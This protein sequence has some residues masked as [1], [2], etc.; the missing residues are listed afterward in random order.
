MMNDPQT[1]D[2]TG[3][4]KGSNTPW[5][6]DKGSRD[7]FTPKFKAFP[8]GPKRPFATPGPQSKSYHCDQCDGSAYTNPW[9]PFFSSSEL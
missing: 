2:Q 6:H 7:I 8:E 4:N 3:P 1:R 5:S 9:Y